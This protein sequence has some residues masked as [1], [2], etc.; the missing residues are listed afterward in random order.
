MVFGRTR[1]ASYL[2]AALAVACGSAPVDLSEGGRDFEAAD[3][4]HV[5]DLWTRDFQIITVDGIENVLT[6]RVTHLSWEFRWA[7][8]VKRAH[9]LRLTPEER[10]D[11][12]EAEFAR[13]EEG[14]EFFV[15][16]MSGVSGTEDLESDKGPWSI[17]LADDRGRQVAPISVE[18]IRRPTP[19]DSAYFDFDLKHRKPYRILF[20]LEAAD[21]QPILS[22]E[23]RSYS[24]RFSSALGQGDAVWETI[25][26]TGGEG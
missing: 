21:G 8:A 17:R 11:L 16:V 2:V 18:R 14:H 9:D 13:L 24:V 10:R 22:P 12:N 6:A 1:R 15:S 3:Y 23:T 25:P 26:G 19:A 5:R 4:G 7:F 20:P